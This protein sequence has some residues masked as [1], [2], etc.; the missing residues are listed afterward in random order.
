M[1][2]N[3]K[4]PIIILCEQP[5]NS[6]TNNEASYSSLQGIA[7]AKYLRRVEKK[8]NPIIFT[9]FLSPDQLLD[10]PNTRIITAIG[11]GYLQIPYTEVQLQEVID[12]IS[13]LNEIQ[14]NDIIINFCQLRSA[15]RESFHIFK[16]KLREIKGSLLSNEQKTEKYKIEFT[17][18]EKNLLKDASAYPLILIEFRRLVTDFQ[19]T[20][21]IE[22]ITEVTEEQFSRFLPPDSD[23]VEYIDVEPKP[24][25]ILFLDDKPSELQDIFKE[26]ESR[27]ISYQVVTS[28]V[29][30]KNVVENDKLN[31][32]TVIVSDYRLFESKSEWKESR[33]QA[34][35]GYDF[36][37]WLSQKQRFY[38]M[39]ALSG[40]SKWFLMESFRKHQVNVKVYSKN[41][42]LT[43]NGARLFV[44]DLEYLGDRQYE[45]LC[46]QPKAKL[47]HEDTEKAGKITNYA[48][49]PYYIY[50]RNHPTYESVEKELNII[51]EKVAREIEYALDEKGN[52]FAPIISAKG[53]ALTNMKGKI[54]DEY[55]VFQLKLLYRR[56]FYYLTLKGFHRD[57]ISR[58]LHRGDTDSE[59]DMSE[60]LIK[61]IPYYLGIQTEGDIP[62]RLLVEEVY[63]LQHYMNLPLYE[64]AKMM[65]QT[66]V[67]FNDYINR[68]LPQK[69]EAKEELARYVCRGDIKAV[70]INEAHII[71]N[72]ISVILDPN[73]AQKLVDE[74][75]EVISIL[76]KGLSKFKLLEDSAKKI[77]ELRTKI[78]KKIAKS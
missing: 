50:H 40:L 13:P 32:Y 22:M 58:L 1:E 33:M 52:N 78:S 43:E 36:L 62:Y 54:I 11:H 26:I 53:N 17:N 2:E 60:Q 10:K 47:W 63:F 21:R 75:E 14:L 23:E 29:E 55:E 38:S 57:A 35:Q 72:K 44:D 69:I 7:Y 51:A 27:K 73:L 41:N 71:L 34:E 61:Q 30:A 12:T 56:I 76:S 49:K 42:V 9:S 20:S 37:L 39:I 68:Y 74:I 70:S 15:V 66:Y 16:G 4:S 46:N 8:C 64:A 31:L 19:D 48:L 45:V 3:S 28:S 67:I 65:D 25:K 77:E 24:W 6:I 18:Y 59:K 5:F